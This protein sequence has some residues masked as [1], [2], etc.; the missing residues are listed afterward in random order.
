M[1][2][3]VHARATV[4]AV[5]IAERIRRG[6]DVD[7]KH[8]PVHVPA[9][10]IANLGPSA[11]SSAWR[12]D[13]PG[14]CTRSAWRSPTRPEPA[15]GFTPVIRHPIIGFGRPREYHDAELDDV[16]PQAAPARGRLNVVIQTAS[17]FK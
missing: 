5:L 12:A 17:V 3:V 6:R 7:R 11:S 16:C 4:T 14:P 10:S 8:A 15:S 2:C 9:V 1:T 13:S